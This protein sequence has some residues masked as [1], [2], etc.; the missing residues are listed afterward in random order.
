M[1]SLR[2]LAPLTLLAAFVAAP[3]AD[4]QTSLLRV[5]G[6]AGGALGFG[7]EAVSSIMDVTADGTPELV[8]VDP[9]ASEVR[10]VNG[11]TETLIVAGWNGRRS[12][13]I[14]R[15]KG[16]CM[17]TV[18]PGNLGSPFAP[19]ATRCPSTTTPWIVTPRSDM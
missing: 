10:I 19:E 16:T 7:S 3:H 15:K 14:A 8:I 18:P 6:G 17:V 5:D 12:V 9:S 13:P 4:A 2:T 1:T 11:A